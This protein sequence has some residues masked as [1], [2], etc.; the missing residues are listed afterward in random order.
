MKTYVNLKINVV[1]SILMGCEIGLMY[2]TL[3][4]HIGKDPHPHD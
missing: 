4:H 3:L 2:G 1:I